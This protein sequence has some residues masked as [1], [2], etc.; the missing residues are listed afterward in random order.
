LPP[1]ITSE[2]SESID[3]AEPETL[4]YIPTV[5]RPQRTLN[6]EKPTGGSLKTGWRQGI[7]LFTPG[8]LIDAVRGITNTAINGNV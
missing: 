4:S 1:T 6:E 2:K 7:D 3:A 5:S 8:V